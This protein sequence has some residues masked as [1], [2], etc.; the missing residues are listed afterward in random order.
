MGV[1]WGAADCTPPSLCF[2]THRGPGLSVQL[3]KAAVTKHLGEPG[4]GGWE[5]IPEDEVLYVCVCV[6]VCMCVCVCVC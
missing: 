1:L 4:E 6:C 5:N 2:I 3:G